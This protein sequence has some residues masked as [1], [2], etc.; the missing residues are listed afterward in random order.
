MIKIIII[1]RLMLGLSCCRGQSATLQRHSAGGMD[2]GSGGNHM[3]SYDNVPETHHNGHHHDTT[4]G[5]AA[6]RNRGKMESDATGQCK[7]I[8]TSLS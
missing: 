4:N 6:F 8:S 2:C 7:L 1:S 5:A 3:E